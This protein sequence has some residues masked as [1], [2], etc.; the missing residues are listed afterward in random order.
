MEPGFPRQ[1]AEDFPGVDTKVD[2]AFEA[3][4]EEI[5]FVWSRGTGNFLGYRRD[6]WIN[7]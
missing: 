5:L 6:N 7:F 4:G 1:I 3:F 2:A